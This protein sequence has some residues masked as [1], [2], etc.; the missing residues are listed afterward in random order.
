MCRRQSVSSVAAVA[1]AL[2]AT[3]GLVA[4]R[5]P[6]IEAVDVRARMLAAARAEDP[7]FP[8]RDGLRLVHFSHI[9]DIDTADGIIHVA[10]ERGFIANM[11]SPRGLNYL[12]FFSAD[13]RWLGKLH[14]TCEPAW[15]AFGKV[16]L[17]GCQTNGYFTWNAWDLRA[18]W[19]N[20]VTVVE[21]A[22]GSF[23]PDEN[24]K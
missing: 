7:Y 13:F 14:V 19:A 9:G 8:E 2:V 16:Y 11:P 12:S 1:V 4:C 18:G 21:P 6:A 22:V 20:R 10:Y 24:A 5:A 23:M 17:R 3:S 15:C